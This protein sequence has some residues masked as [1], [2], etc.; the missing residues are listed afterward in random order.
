MDNGNVGRGN[1]LAQNFERSMTEAP[2]FNPEILPVPEDK[3]KDRGNQLEDVGNNPNANNNAMYLD[4][5]MLGAS[6]INAARFGE[7]GKNPALGEV[8][9]EDSIGMRALTEDQITGADIEISKFSKDG[10]SNELAKKLDENKKVT[11]LY[12]QTLNFIEQSKRSLSESFADRRY[13][14]GDEK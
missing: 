7:N 6:A 12:R 9:D 8:I 11:N 4:P 1:N 2:Q 5:S 10:I 13:L 3:E 14:S